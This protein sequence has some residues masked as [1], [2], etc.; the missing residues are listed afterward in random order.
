[1]RL[2]VHATIALAALSS[3]VVA[4]S[5]SADIFHLT[6]NREIEGQVLE[7]LGDTLRVRVAMGVVDLKK[8]DILRREKGRTPWER[9]DRIRTRYPNTAQGHYDLSKWCRKNKL[10]GERRKHLARAIELD[11][12]H[13]AARKALGHVKRD[14]A[15]ID[16]A[17]Q[18]RSKPANA[19]ELEERRRRE[20]ED[21]LLRELVANW[22]GRVRA[23]SRNQLNCKDCKPESKRFRKG[24]ERI[25]AIRDSLAI[26]ALTEVLSRGNTAVRRLLVESLA[27]FEEDEATMNLIILAV[28]DREPAVR[29]LAAIELIQRKDE[30]VVDRLK[31]AL[32]SDSEFLL[33]NAATVL[34]VLKVES[35]VEELIALLSVKARRRVRV[36]RPLFLSRTIRS[37]GND[38]FVNVGG[39][40]LRYRPGR[41]G[42]LNETQAMMGTRDSSE[43]RVV[44]IYRT[45]IQEALIA[46]TGKNHGFDRD[47]WLEWW[48]NRTADD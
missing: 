23:V 47:A 11:P 36:T 35:V 26:P 43:I 24:R 38:R 45:E 2:L 21:N 31:D 27:Q 20:E 18:P 14:G 22:F 15:W 41:I 25:L 13:A 40:R 42:V 10:T 44:D 4:T 34:G 17:R 1:M 7:D 33:R 16:P 3:A 19:E 12:D 39:R 5:A 30:R 46:I 9:Y 8:A 6:G 48:R 32:A 29:R 37:F 28:M